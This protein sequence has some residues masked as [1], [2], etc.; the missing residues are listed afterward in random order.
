MP[1]VEVSGP[2]IDI[3]R[4]RTLV[5]EITKLIVDTYQVPASLA[6]VIIRENPPENIG[7]GGFLLADRPIEKG[8]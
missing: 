1:R 5:R 3:E 7:I 4:K 6:I 8:G 2:P